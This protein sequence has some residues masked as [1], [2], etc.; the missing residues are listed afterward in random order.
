M[1]PGFETDLRYHRC[2]A[3]DYAKLDPALIRA[4]T[5][6]G[7]DDEERLSVFIRIAGDLDQDARDRLT[8]LG[9]RGLRPGQRVLTADLAIPALRDLVDKN[10]VL[11]LSLAG[12]SRPL[13]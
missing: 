2:Q 6:R 1:P 10:W 12:K 7:D 8:D 11:T 5:S 3:M 9:C 13:K 4:L